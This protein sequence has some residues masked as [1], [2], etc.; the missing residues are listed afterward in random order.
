MIENPLWVMASVRDRQL[1][2]S[3][4]TVGRGYLCLDP[5]RFGDFLTHDLWLDLDPGGRILVRVS[6]EGEKDDIMFY[7][8]RAF[9]SLK[10]TEGEMARIFVNKVFFFII[11]SLYNTNML[12]R[13]RPLSGT[14]YLGQ[15]SNL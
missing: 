7:F 5:R 6:M 4:D 11:V 12:V 8:G 2:G 13:C 9:R 14:A 1:V 3:H 10:R 15:C